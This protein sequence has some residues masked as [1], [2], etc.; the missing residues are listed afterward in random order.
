[1]KRQTEIVTALDITKNQATA[2]VDEAEENVSEVICETTRE[3]KSGSHKT[4]RNR[5]VGISI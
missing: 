3:E 1:M 5:R 4:T 2:R